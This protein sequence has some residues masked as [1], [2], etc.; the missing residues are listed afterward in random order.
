MSVSLWP[1]L[2]Q[3]QCMVQRGFLSFPDLGPYSFIGTV[4]YQIMEVDT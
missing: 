2:V 3:R 4:G 1:V